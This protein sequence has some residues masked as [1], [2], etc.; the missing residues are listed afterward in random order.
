M[1]QAKHPGPP[2]LPRRLAIPAAAA[3][4]FRLVLPEGSELHA[5][6]IAALGDLG[7]TDASLRLVSG[8]FRAFSYLTGQPDRSGA[9]LATYG[10]PTILA[11]PVTLIGANALVGANAEGQ[12]ALHCHAVVVDKAGQVHGGHLPPDACIVGAEGLVVQVL[13]LA[14]GGFAVGY[15][16]ETNYSIFQPR[17]MAAEA[18]E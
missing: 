3:G 2:E 17:A 13:G 16:A 1:R 12:P 7:L 9:R 18:A 5:G 11:P 6:L 10:A 15:D 14:E 4:E 8:S